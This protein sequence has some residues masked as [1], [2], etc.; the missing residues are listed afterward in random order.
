MSAFRFVRVLAMLVV[1]A[2]SC[3]ATTSFAA[4]E[5]PVDQPRL[6]WRNGDMLD[7]E[8]T[9]VS[10][11][12]LSWSAPQFVDSLRLNF[13]ALRM[14]RFPARERELGEADDTAQVIET[15]DG[16]RFFGNVQSSDDEYLTV[17]TELF[18]ELDLRRDAVGMIANP[19]ERA[20][21]YSGPRGLRGWSTLTYGRKL[22]EWEEIANGRLTTRLV[23]AE[24]YRELPATGSVDIDVEFLWRN[25][26]SFQLRF[27]TPYGKATRETV[28]VE[29]RVSGYVIQ[30]LGSNGRFRQLDT[31][32]SRTTK[33]Q[34]L[35][36][37]N[38]S[39]SEL[40]IF[41]NRKYLGK[42][43]V[44]K[45]DSSGPAGI[46]IKNTG[47]RLTLSRLEIRASSSLDIYR[48]DQTRDTVLLDD[49]TS[50]TGDV[51]AVN[52]E[53]VSVVDGE[54]TREVKWE[55]IA[56]IAFRAA[57]QTVPDPDGVPDRFPQ[58]VE[59]VFHN[60][61]TLRGTVSGA[62][63][64]SLQLTVPGIRNDVR[65][66]YVDLERIVFGPKVLP[67][68][69]GAPT[70]L[71]SRN[72]DE[73]F[74][75][76]TAIRLH[77]RLETGENNAIA[78]R[79]EGAE[80][81]VATSDATEIKLQLA[82]QTSSVAGGPQD[83]L[84][85][86]RNGDVVPGQLQQAGATG[87]EV[88]SKFSDLVRLSSADVRAIE[89][90]SAP[91]EPLTGFDDRWEVRTVDD[92]VAEFVVNADELRLKGAG[93]VQRDSI[94][95]GCDRIQF[96]MQRN[97]GTGGMFLYLIL[98]AE[99]RS[100]EKKLPFY[101]MDE[102]LFVLG[103]RRNAFIPCLEGEEHF[104][105]VVETRDPFRVEVNGKTV[106]S[107]EGNENGGPWSGLAFEV[108]DGPLFGPA[109]K[110]KKQPIDV[111]VRDLVVSQTRRQSI[112]QTT[113]SVDPQTLLTIPRNRPEESLTH[114]AIGTNSDA[115]RGNLV[116]L[117]ESGLRMR[118]KSRD[119]RLPREAVSG[120]VWLHTEDPANGD[121][122]LNPWRIVLRDTT[123][124]TF[125]D[126]RM[127]EGESLTL[128][129][130][131]PRLG[132]CSIPVDGIQTILRGHHPTG[133]HGHAFMTWKMKHAIEPRFESQSGD[134]RF[135][136][137]L[138]GKPISFNA[139]MLENDRR[140]DLIDYQGKV[141]VLDFWAAWCAPCI[142]NMPQ[143]IETVKQFSPEQVA[144]VG[145]NQG[146]DPATIA[147]LVR[148]KEWDLTVA[149]D[150]E[151]TASRELE[152]DTIPQTV[153][154]DQEGNVSAVYLGVSRGLHD[155]ITA[156]IK[157]L[158]GEE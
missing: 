122:N 6:Y 70:L 109:V 56:E 141:V 80:A 75:Q 142:R 123:T 58:M 90:A 10:S 63:D 81:P 51:R 158:L 31:M 88:T 29:T 115:I 46:Y 143:L 64:A 139:K 100:D 5:D 112:R 43:S 52:A 25:N 92:A 45:Q 48:A 129:G 113:G 154:L 57:D 2:V 103:S 151:S 41:R 40:S 114:L 35:L 132:E 119:M 3:L 89:L 54:E 7:G 22:S 157:R 13:D 149:V 27:L 59:C 152:V 34:L 68:K 97:Q 125:V 116:A 155:E 108:S 137:E 126:A 71:L 110:R 36:R 111:T 98:T 55:N 18:G 145:V 78:W 148:A 153:I 9:G 130:T 135:A 147:T 99:N 67:P 61:E 121:A 49:N 95:A 105:V 38:H 16:N 65:C 156:E 140:L 12:V 50:I 69:N 37:W 19:V 138:L 28:K 85:Y 102:K 87:I 106:Y 93:A 66:S 82:T 11:R 24:L 146:D 47:P 91:V 15:S 1:L 73:P 62:D 42:I 76:Q 128:E 74:S 8:L 60:G 104:E 14:I 118:S 144:L 127:V 4:P 44:P 120:V 96:N 136:S 17:Q 72:S 150:V 101:F 20:H 107:V 117:D 131:H 32:S 77:G 94:L 26:P 79:P 83:D 21:V 86:F 39:A 33:C 134:H 30:S 23:A 53:V 84:I 133:F 124:L